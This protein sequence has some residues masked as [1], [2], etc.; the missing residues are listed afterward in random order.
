M[1]EITNDHVINL[2]QQTS[3]RDKMAGRVPLIGSGLSILVILMYALG[4]AISIDGKNYVGWMVSFYYWGEQ[5]IYHY[6]VFGVN[7][8]LSLAVVL[9]VIFAIVTAANWKYGSGRKRM[10]LSILNGAVLIYAGAAFLNVVSLAESTV[11]ENFQMTLVAAQKSG[12]Y[13][14]RMTPV[15][16]AILCFVLAAAI[17]AGGIL[18]RNT[19]AAQRPIDEEEETEE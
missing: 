16:A 4:P 9:P 10:V 12:T 1:E 17:M 19:L 18:G 2:T 7:F 14:E 6:Y 3:L 8:V 5:Y 15:I 11:S 13:F